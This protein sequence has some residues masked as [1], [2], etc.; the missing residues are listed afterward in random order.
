M[1]SKLCAFIK[2]NNKIFGWIEDHCD[3]NQGGHLS[4]NMFRYTLS[5]LK[6]LF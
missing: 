6:K 3:T 4:A 2:V 1:N 5:D